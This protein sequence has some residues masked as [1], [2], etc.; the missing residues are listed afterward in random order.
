M[1]SSCW[2][3]NPGPEPRIPAEDAVGLILL[4]LERDLPGAISVAAPNPDRIPPRTRARG[5]G[6][7]DRNRCAPVVPPRTMCVTRSMQNAHRRK[8]QNLG[9]SS[10]LMKT[11]SGKSRRA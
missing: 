1:P 6:M 3:A 9:R 11:P 7:G 10:R 4:R 2:R 8:W 5:P